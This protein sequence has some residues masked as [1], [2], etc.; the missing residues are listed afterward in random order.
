MPVER[1]AVPRCSF[2][3]GRKREHWQRRCVVVSYGHLRCFGIVQQKDRHQQKFQARPK[4]WQTEVRSSA[5][6]TKP[7]SERVNI[8][9]IKAYSGT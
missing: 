9:V 3:L 8:T 1:K 2:L 7:S 5:T 6:T 4:R